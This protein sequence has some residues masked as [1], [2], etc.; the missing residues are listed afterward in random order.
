MHR[1]RPKPQV[2]Y[3][4]REN[5]RRQ[6]IVY[7]PGGRLEAQLVGIGADPRQRDAGALLE[8]LAD[9]PSQRQAARPERGGGGREG[10][11]E[12]DKAGG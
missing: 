3:C 8:D 7:R 9:L 4:C 10:P 6:Y 1:L 11:R 2:V 5:D 12:K